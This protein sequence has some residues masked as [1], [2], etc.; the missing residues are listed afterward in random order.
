[1]EPDND[2]LI[3][4]LDA[5]HAEICAAQRR[6]LTLIAQVDLREA[7]RD[8]GA[9]DTA[10]WLWMRYGL[11]DWKARR[12]LAASHALKTLP[13]TGA[14]L[15][16]GDLGI[17]KVVELTRFA[18]PGDEARLLPWARQVSCGA[19]RKRADLLL[20]TAEEAQRADDARSVTWWYFDD[21]RR[22]ALEA[23]LPAAQGAVVAKALARL[24]EDLPAMP[25]EEHRYFVRARRADALVAL[26]SARVADDPDQD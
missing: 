21:D 14:A 26:C 1:M 16:S 18:T 7:W 12:W 11:S 9:R 6:M 20:R 17:D 8:A 24:A 5:T 4:E 15:S 19:I 23:E 22:F 2:R 25:G 3:D 13:L 10:H